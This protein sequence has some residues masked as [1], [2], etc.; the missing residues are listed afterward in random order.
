MEGLGLIDLLHI[1]KIFGPGH[2]L[3][4]GMISAIF[5]ASLDI[6]LGTAEGGLIYV[7][8]AVVTSTIFR[9]AL[10]LKGNFLLGILVHPDP[11][12]LGQLRRLEKTQ[13]I[14]ANSLS[15]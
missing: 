13:E 1:T 8:G 3:D 12:L 6:I 9:P 10:F 14:P 2:H 4:P 7:F 15:L 5:A 11:S